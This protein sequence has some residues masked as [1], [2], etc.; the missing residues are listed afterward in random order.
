MKGSTFLFVARFFVLL[1]SFVLC[2]FV[3]IC[4]F[5]KC[6]TA[7]IHSCLQRGF[8]VCSQDHRDGCRPTNGDAG[9]GK[10]VDCIIVAFFLFF[11]V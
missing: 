10:K 2:G 7:L 3:L 5:R 8:D 1:N 6:L 9:E 4:R 11:Y